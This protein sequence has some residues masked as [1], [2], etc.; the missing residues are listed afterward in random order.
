MARTPKLTYY[1]IKRADV[2]RLDVA[3]VLDMLRYDDAHVEPNA[4]EGFYLFS[5]VK[6]PC[7]ERWE[8][9]LCPVHAATRE[10]WRVHELAQRPPR[11]GPIVT[12]RNS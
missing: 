4:P 3:G 8:S 7:W 6:G 11:V 10:Q 2:E 12:G 9:F 1:L 5:N